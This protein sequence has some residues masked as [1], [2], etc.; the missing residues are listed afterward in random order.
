MC[1]LHVVRVVGLT[2][3]LADE[4]HP[5]VCPLEYERERL[6]LNPKFIVVEDHPDRGEVV[7]DGRPE[8]LAGHVE[9][10]VT[11]H[12]DRGLRGVGH[13]RAQHSRRGRA[14][15]G[16]ARHDEPGSRSTDRHVGLGIRDRVADVD[17]HAPRLRDH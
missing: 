13:R 16:E 15:L 12:R 7:L 8:D 2:G 1:E 5:W 17:E 9:R 11:G 10:A 6:A 3:V 4:T 14:H